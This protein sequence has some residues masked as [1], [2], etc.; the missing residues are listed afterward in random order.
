[1]LHE[2]MILWT[3]VV[4]LA[5]TGCGGPPR[6]ARVALVATA[7]ALRA[8]DEEVAPR[9]TTAADAARA[10]SDGWAAYDAAMSDWNAVEAALR[11]AHNALLTTQ[12]GLDAW[13]AGDERGWLASVPCLVE[14]LDRLRLGLEA[15]DVRLEALTQAVAVAGAFAGRCEVQP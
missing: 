10:H 9:Y 3:L 15:V 11:V 4:G 1:M 7:Q 6:E 5:L 13:E 14:A 8:T 12:A 2:A